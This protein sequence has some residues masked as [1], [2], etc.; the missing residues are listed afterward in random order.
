MSEVHYFATDAAR[1]GDMQTVVYLRHSVYGFV[2]VMFESGNLPTPE[3]QA[4][5]IERW[6]RVQ[7]KALRGSFRISELLDPTSWSPRKPLPARAVPY[8]RQNDRQ[9]NGRRR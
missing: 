8:Y 2:Q 5:I 6:Q 1:A 3:E 7:D 9:L 4:A